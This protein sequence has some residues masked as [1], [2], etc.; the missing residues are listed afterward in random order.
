MLTR[1]GSLMTDDNGKHCAGCAIAT[2]FNTIEAAPL[3]MATSAQ[4]AE[5]Y[6]LTRACT[7]ANGKTANIYTDIRY[8]SRVA[9]NFGT[10]WNQCGFLNSV[11][12]KLKMTPMF[13]NYWMLYFYL[14]L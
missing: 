4:Q 2:P 10:L 11:E 7:L 8:A 9:H 5:L 3:P 14:L 1:H 6:T 12:I 13:R